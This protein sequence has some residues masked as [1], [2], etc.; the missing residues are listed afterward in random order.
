MS[1]PWNMARVRSRQI[2][3]RR[4]VLAPVGTP[5]QLALGIPYVG[6]PGMEACPCGCG[7]AQHNSRDRS[8]IPLEQAEWMGFREASR[9]LREASL[10]EHQRADR[11]NAEM[12]A[13]I[14]QAEGIELPKPKSVLAEKPVPE[15]PQTTKTCRLCCGEAIGAWP[16]QVGGP[17]T[18]HT[19]HPGEE[20]DTIEKSS[21]FGPL[22]AG[23][24]CS[25][26]S[27]AER[28]ARW[29][30]AVLFTHMS[31]ARVQALV[32]SR[33]GR[34]VYEYDTGN[35]TGTQ[36]GSKTTLEEAMAAALGFEITASSGMKVCGWSG[37]GF[38][39][40]RGEMAV[41]GFETAREAAISALRH[42]S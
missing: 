17:P 32:R 38:A 34:I 3:H 25:E 19:C 18:H 42:R 29:Y 14:E 40:R 10:T 20:R 35:D 31:G 13:A 41:C 6:G 15:I 9:H 37:S 1:K 24:V 8:P 22:P 26:Y 5:G 2:P 33:N 16:P 27:N 23:W 39:W 11:E 21:P 30:V 7:Y 28:D 12:L 4:S 36:C